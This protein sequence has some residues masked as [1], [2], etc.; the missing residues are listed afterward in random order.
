MENKNYTVIYQVFV[1]KTKYLIHIVIYVTILGGDNNWKYG[2]K[3]I[4]KLDG[5][6]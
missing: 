5:T 6:K 4:S 2:N 1:C 3:G